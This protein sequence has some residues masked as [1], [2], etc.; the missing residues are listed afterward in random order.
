MGNEEFS[1]E[2]KRKVL[3]W[4]YRH[5]CICG[6]ACGLD[7]EIA[8]IN[9]AKSR[10]ADDIDNAIPVCY[11]CHADLGRYYDKHPRGTKYK[12]EEIKKRRN[13]VYEQY[14]SHLVP[15]LLP[16][17]LPAQL[18]KVI[19]RII[20]FDRFIPVKVKGIIHVFL[21]GEDLGPIEDSKPYYSGRIIWNLNPGVG[22]IGNFTLPRKHETKYSDGKDLQLELR[23]TIIDTYEREHILLPICFTYAWAE[24][25]WF[26]EPTEF[27]QL[28]PYLN[29]TQHKHT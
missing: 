1:E 6:K 14:T 9:P 27:R 13:Q 11:S 20:P 7:I 26:L 2:V 22:F 21:D 18:P 5:C 16:T 3:L 8:H 25:S 17:I 4:S 19:F 23:M 12:D 10:G 24:K 28:K 29:S 15:A